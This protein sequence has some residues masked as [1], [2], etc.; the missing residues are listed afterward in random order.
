MIPHPLLD[1]AKKAL[2]IRSDKELCNRL[3]LGRHAIS[4]VRSTG[5]ASRNIVYAVLNATDWRPS[6]LRAKMREQG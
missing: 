1:E 6:E 2:G 3:A 4:Q 5:K